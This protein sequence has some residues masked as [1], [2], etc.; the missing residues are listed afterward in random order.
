MNY[1]P[2]KD[3]DPD[4]SLL[5]AAPAPDAR[6]NPAD[7]FGNDHPMELEI[8][9]G[10]GSFLLSAAQERPDHNF[11]GVEWAAKFARYTADRMARHGLTNV[12]ILRTDAAALIAQLPAAC[13]SALHLYHPDPWPKKR[14]HKRRLVQD[15]FVRHAARVLIPGSLWRIQ[16]DHDSY[17]EWMAEKLNTPQARLWFTPQP[18]PPNDDS[19]VPTNWQI[20]FSRQGKNIHRMIF[21]RTPAIMADKK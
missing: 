1:K 14:H 16:T 5:V 15:A 9:C 11:L 13:L 20:K 6:L 8:G 21:E 17:A 18:L 10:K 12:R 7:L 4:L 19:E 3:R 2:L